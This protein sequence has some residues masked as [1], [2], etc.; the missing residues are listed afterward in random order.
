VPLQAATSSPLVRGGTAVH[1]MATTPPPVKVRV[2]RAFLLQGKRIEIGKEID[3]SKA[4]AVDLVSVNK[5]EFVRAA[6]AAPP[7]PKP[8]PNPATKGTQP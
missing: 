2:L 8:A 4:L 7:A 1:A 3:V 6:A 5:A